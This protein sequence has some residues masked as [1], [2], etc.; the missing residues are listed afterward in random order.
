[1]AQAM[2]PGEYLDQGSEG[3]AVVLLQLFLLFGD[4]NHKII[5]DGDYGEET[6]TGVKRLQEEL[7][8]KGDDIDGNFG[9]QTRAALLRQRN[10]DIN[11]ITVINF[12]QPTKAVVPDP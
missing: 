2:F 3:G 12:T 8:F 10:I 9:P 4:Y 6:A 5:A 1:M 7:Q 11:A